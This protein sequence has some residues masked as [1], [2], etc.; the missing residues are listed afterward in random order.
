MRNTIGVLPSQDIKSMISSGM[1][2]SKV[3]IPEGNIQ[4]GSIDLRLG[5]GEMIRLPGIFSPE[6]DDIA[7]FARKMCDKANFYRRPL[8]DEGFVLET[9]VP[10]LVPNEEVLD[11]GEYFS[12]RANP[13]STSGRNNLQVRLVCNCHPEFDSIPAGYKGPTYNIIKANSYP[14]RIKAGQ[15]FNQVRFANGRMSDCRLAPHQLEMEHKK[16]GLVFD[17]KG[18]KILSKNLK[19][20]GSSLVLTANLKNVEEDKPAVLKAKDSSQHCLS[21]A[22][23]N[24]PLEDFFEEV[25]PSKEGFIPLSK[26]GFY[27][28]STNEAVAVPPYLCCEMVD[29]NSGIGEFRSHYAGFFDPGWGCNPIHHKVLGTPAVLEIIP[30]ED[31]LLWHGSPVC[32][33]EYFYMTEIPPVVYGDAGNNYHL[34]AGPRTAKQ[35]I[36]TKW[37]MN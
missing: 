28:L 35:F 29:Y 37:N 16:H 27:I 6:M 24:V 13:K 9:G 31:I 36:S 15:T 30:H 7:D 25:K 18:R 19:M 3:K 8:T 11:L 20:T 34:Q 21:Y 23:K 22:S 1:I 12:G 10:Y 4:P 33:M 5:Q 2:T 14:I 17:L 32:C 26:G